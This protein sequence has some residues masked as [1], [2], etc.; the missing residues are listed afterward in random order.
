[1]ALFVYSGDKLNI[2]LVLEASQTNM[3]HLHRITFVASALM[4]KSHL[5]GCG[6]AFFTSFDAECSQWSGVRAVRGNNAAEM[7]ITL[8]DGRRLTQ[9]TPPH[10]Q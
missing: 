10:T 1:M 5:K 2:A 7:A 3:L 4:R 8:R 9:S 6:P